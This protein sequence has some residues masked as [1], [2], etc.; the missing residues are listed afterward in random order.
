MGL[1]AEIGLFE[2]Q[3]VSYNRAVR[4]QSSQLQPPAPQFME[5][6]F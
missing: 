3:E 2:C 1:A 5:E 6:H 4:S